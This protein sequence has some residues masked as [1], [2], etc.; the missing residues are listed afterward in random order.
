[1]FR[2]RRMASMIALLCSFSLVAAACGDDDTATD[3]TDDTEA[4]AA[5]EGTGDEMAEGGDLSGT[6]AGAGSSAQGAAMDAWIV[7]FQTNNPDVTVNYDPVGSG[8][9]REQFLSGG[10]AFAGSDSLMDEE[11]YATSQE[12]C[13][14]DRGAIHLPQYISPI[15]VAFNLPGIETLNMTPETLAG[16]F[17]DEI[18]SWD[19]PAIAEDNPDVELPDLAINPVHRS[20][21]SGTTKNFTDY[22]SEAA[23]DVWTEGAVEVWPYGG[24]GAQ[25]TSGVVAAIEAGEGSIGYADA[26]QVQ[27]LGQVAVGVGDEFVEFSP[28]AAARIVDVSERTEGFNE[29]DFQYDLVRDT[30]EEGVYPIAL[31]SYQIVC[32]DY[33]DQE[34]A[35]LVKGF[36]EYISSEEGQQAAAAEA[37]SAP[38]S[39]ELRSQLSEA[40]AEI[41]VAS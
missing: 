29:L 26:S 31:V 20:D 19:D 23:P 15:A 1:M 39:D 32:L 28:E 12:R 3:T 10:V 7:G 37:G 14:S 16:I 9:G 2:T 34:T 13:A 30:T 24:E 25:G 38:I 27:D 40:I 35:D 4:P 41:G 36:M 11:E 6:L 8:G 33:D 5:G 22:L 17:A 18:T 21:E